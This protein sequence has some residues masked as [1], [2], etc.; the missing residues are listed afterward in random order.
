MR[1]VLAYQASSLL[2]IA[3]LLT[4][5]L[6]DTADKIHKVF[7]EGIVRPIEDT[8]FPKQDEAKAKT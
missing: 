1:E 6:P 7:S 5:F 8:L 3:D 4:P 2:E